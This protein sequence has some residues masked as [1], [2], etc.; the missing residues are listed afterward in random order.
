[1]LTSVGLV[2]RKDSAPNSH[3]HEILVL[4][5]PVHMTPTDTL[6]IGINGLLMQGNAP[7][8]LT[9]SGAPAVVL[10]Q[11]DRAEWT[12]VLHPKPPGSCPVAPYR[13]LLRTARLEIS[14]DDKDAMNKWMD[15][16]DECREAFM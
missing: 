10:V 16:I 8:Q 7:V 4:Q 15:A 6:S 9:A 5:R 14:F 2:L 12:Q 13:A 1:M 11:D 3:V